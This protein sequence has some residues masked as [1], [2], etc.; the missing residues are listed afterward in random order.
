MSEI[1]NKFGEE[2]FVEFFG[3]HEMALIVSGLK[4]TRRAAKGRE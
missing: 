2:I 1:V 3:C 4:G